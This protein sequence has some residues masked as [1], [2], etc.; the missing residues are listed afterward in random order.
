MRRSG[1]AP[2]WQAPAAAGP[3]G[4][5]P[6]PRAAASPPPC[7]KNGPGAGVQSHVERAAPPGALHLQVAGG[8][9]GLALTHI[10]RICPQQPAISTTR[11][12][13]RQN[14]H[15]PPYLQT[16]FSF[17]LHQT[18]HP[19][20]IIDDS[21]I[22]SVVLHIRLLVFCMFSVQTKLARCSLPMTRHDFFFLLNM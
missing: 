16:R 13:S 19:V 14:R 12:V 11:S 17:R 7:P 20:G 10:H 9:S 15:M 21:H 6:N 8:E 18:S 2:C 3:R 5:E 22:K 4:H 1:A